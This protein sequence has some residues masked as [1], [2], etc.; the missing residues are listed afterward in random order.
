MLNLLS[1]AMKFSKDNQKI[2]IVCMIAENKE[3]LDFT[4]IKI[5]VID[6]G[7]GIND[8]DKN[9]LFKPFFKTSD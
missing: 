5:Q 8:Q 4:T 3:K 6:Q 2:T 9:N 7:I 1:N